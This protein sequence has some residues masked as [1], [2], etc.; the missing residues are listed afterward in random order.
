MVALHDLDLDG[1]WDP[2]AH[3][4]QMAG[5]YVQDNDGESCD[6]EKPVWDDDIDI[7]DI[8]PPVASSSK[9]G[10]NDDGHYRLEDEVYGDGGEWDGEEWDGTEEMRK[11]KLQEYMDSLL[12]LE[13]ND[14][15]SATRLE[16]DHV[17]H[18]LPV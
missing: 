3:D 18:H 4:R 10:N 12:G 7:D 1:D 11:R 17:S 8:V 16:P 13:F 5:I 9:K 2:E 15:A 14:M 6:E